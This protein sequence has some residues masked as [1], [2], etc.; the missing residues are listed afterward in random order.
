M[1]DG[2]IIKIHNSELRALEEAGLCDEQVSYL[3]VASL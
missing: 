3:H 1:G 2:E